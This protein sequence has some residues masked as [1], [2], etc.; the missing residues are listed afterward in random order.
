[1]QLLRSFTIKKERS[2]NCRFSLRNGSNR[3]LKCNYSID[4]LGELVI[5]LTNINSLLKPD[6]IVS[7]KPPIFR[8]HSLYGKYKIS[9]YFNTY[10]TFSI[11]LPKLDKPLLQ[12]HNKPNYNKIYFKS[13]LWTISFETEPSMKAN[14]Q[15]SKKRRVLFHTTNQPQSPASWTAKNEHKALESGIRREN[16]INKHN[17]YVVKLDVLVA[18]TLN[19][20]CVSQL[21][22]KSPLKFFSIR[23]DHTQ[24]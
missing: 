23:L 10:I 24:E 11:H 2:W 15:S 22:V 5:I 17:G 13:L 1:M 16:D 12:V 14:V 20:S 8:N 3:Q 21:L 4:S 18:V 9:I 7:I 6:Q 19:Y